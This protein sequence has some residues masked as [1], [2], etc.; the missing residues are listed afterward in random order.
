MS[1]FGQ[2]AQQ[3]QSTGLFGSTFGTNQPQQ[4]GSLFGEQQT[5]QQPKPQGSLFGSLEQQQQQEQQPQQGTSSLFGMSTQQQQEPQQQT[6]GL[7]GGSQQQSQ[8]SPGGLFSGF[9]SGTQT[10]PQQGCGLFSGLGSSTTQQ[11]PQSGSLF[12]SSAAQQQPSQQQQQQQGSGLFSGFGQNTPQPQQLQQSQAQQGG[13]FFSG[14]GST[15]QQPQQ[16]FGATLV[17]GGQ[18]AP[19]QLGQSQ[20]TGPTLWTPGQG[21]TGVHRTVP[22]QMSILMDKWQPTCRNSPFRTHLYNNVGEDN[23][24]FFQPG[25]NDDETKWEDALRKRPS[26]GYVPVLVQGFWELG[27]RAQKQKGFLTMMQSRLHEINNALTEL[28]SRHDLK[29]SVKIA[30]C[31]RKHIV[32]SQRCL[33]LAGKTQVLRNRGYVMDETEEE[34]QKKLRQLERSVFDPSLNG[35]AEE[36]W[37]RMLAIRE[38]SKRLQL[39][40]ERTGQ[41]A[42]R[43]VDD[44]LDETALKTA[45]KILDD[46]AS[47]IRHLNKELAAAQ[48]DFELLHGSST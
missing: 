3:P 9:G 7:F 11:Q 16:P 37:A 31:R 18:Q 12:G 27:N 43:Q 30:A 20:Q 2:P 46:Y 19:P 48:K 8:Q 14:F 29:I 10:Q 32:L 42:A 4:T 38:R 36:I 15:I 26:P 39:E 13:G 34:L 28:L 5:S 41:D 33:A 17:A 6:S 45:K 35:C 40:M 23:A 44:G 21:M 1:L 47:Q 24:P 25:A 22:M